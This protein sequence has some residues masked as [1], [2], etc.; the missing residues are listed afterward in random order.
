MATF[1]VKK[2]CMGRE[3]LTVSDTVKVLTPSVYNGTQ[4]TAPIAGRRNKATAAIVTVMSESIW[5]TR[6]G[7]D[8]SSTAGVLLSERDQYPLGSYSEIA[9]FEA[10][11][12]TGTDATIEV[13]Y[14]L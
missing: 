8:P 14:F 13:E 7:T 6:E 5:V 3:R 10:L 1:D 2:V 12:A 4:E 9:K 11:R